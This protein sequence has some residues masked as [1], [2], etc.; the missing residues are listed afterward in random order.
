MR[1]ALRF[2]KTTLVGELVIVLPIWVAALLL[3]KAIKGA[4]GVLRPI[5]TMLPQNIVHENVVAVALLLIICFSAGL[6]MRAAL[7]RRMVGWFETK[8]LE[9]IP[10]YS[11]LRSITQRL[12]GQGEDQSF[13]AALVVIEDALVPAFIVECHADG[14]CTVFVPASP[15]PATGAIISCRRNGFTGS[16]SRC[17]APLV[18]SPIGAKARASC[19]LRCD[20]NERSIFWQ[21]HCAVCSDALVTGSPPT[22][23][24][25]CLVEK[26]QKYLADFQWTRNRWPLF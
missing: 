8:F 4:L 10:G 2:V 3:I 5:A 26:Q 1:P 19:S 20:R 6:L 13:Q 9:Y 12:T 11:L 25:Y 18:A 7:T 24:R 21:A 15:T 14:Q 23:A 16:M 22:D 17:T